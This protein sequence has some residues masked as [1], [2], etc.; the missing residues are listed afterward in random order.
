MA[1]KSKTFCI[2]PWVHLHSWAGGEVY[3]CC[4]S[5]IEPEHRIGNLQ[6]TSLQDLY[7]SDKMKEI[8]VKMLSGEQVE[9]CTRCYDQERYG[10]RSMRMNSNKD[11][12]QHDDL[13]D[14]TLPDGTSPEMR[15]TYWDIRFSNNCNMKCRSCGSDFST[16]WYE[17]NAKMWGKPWTDITP[18][19]KRVRA[20]FDTLMSEAKD[21]IKNFEKIYFAGG[22]PLIM[23]EHWQ[24]VEEVIEQKN[25]DVHIHYQTNLS[26]LTYKDKNAIDLWKQLKNV[27]INASLDA[28]GTLGEYMRKGP[29]WQTVLS[30]LELLRDECPE[31]ERHSTCTVS[32]MNVLHI[33]EFHKYLYENN[34]ISCENFGLNPLFTPPYYRVETLPEEL[35]QV[36]KE[37]IHAHI[38]ELESMGNKKYAKVIS[39]FEGIIKMLNNPSTYSLYWPDYCRITR[40]L[41]D[42]R[43]EN[44]LSVLPEFEPYLL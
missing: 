27:V 28:S 22:E 20:D 9:S 19:V 8:R 24:F 7:N 44:V 3:T 30:N 25:F 1:E 43:K 35:K 36:A 39:E 37:K 4:L 41:D 12:M 10:F 29:S 42:I 31:I 34:L 17:D 38:L 11:F 16:L 14:S 6:D 15:I 21:Q 2:L 32:L 26:Q 18:R 23:P 33:T 5:N 40:Q 13:V